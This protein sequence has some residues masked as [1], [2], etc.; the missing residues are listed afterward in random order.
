MGNMALWDREWGFQGSRGSERANVDCT[1]RS[2]KFITKA[3]SDCEIAPEAVADQVR[4]AFS[5]HGGWWSACAL[6]AKPCL[7]M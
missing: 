5:S 2:R 1:G 7:E 6:S 4:R 3:V